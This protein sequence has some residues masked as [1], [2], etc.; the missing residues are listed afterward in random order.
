M[1]SNTV[2]QGREASTKG[3]T[4][5]RDSPEMSG[6][7]VQHIVTLD[8]RSSSQYCEGHVSGAFSCP[9]A[10]V[11]RYCAELP[12]RHVNLRLITDVAGADRQEVQRYFTQSGYMQFTLFSSAEVECTCNTPTGGFCWRPSPFLE[13]QAAS[14]SPGL[15]LDVGT[16]AG[17]DLVFLASRGWAVLG[18][19]IRKPL[20]ARCHNFSAHYAL[21]HR[22]GV[23]VAD[24]RRSLP[25]RC[26]TFDLVHVCRFIHRPLI[27][28]LV[29]LLRP[30]GVLIYSHFLQGCERTGRGCP[31]NDSGFFRLGEL[32]S[33]LVGEALT[34]L[35]TE[36]DYLEDGRPMIHLLAQKR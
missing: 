9:W 15:A 22:S 13:R 17:R 21:S 36:K 18:F 27:P 10:T 6:G 24:A 26:G 8:L 12:P 23:C 32:E 14:L 2:S 28:A 7:D 5:S 20:A 33:L 31:K 34:L 19:D 30:G 29:A 3:G 4:N 35:V 1:Q 11:E 25:F 16:G